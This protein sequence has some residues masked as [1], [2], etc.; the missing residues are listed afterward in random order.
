LTYCNI[1]GAEWFQV[2]YR[3]SF[4]EER[5]VFLYFSQ[6]RTIGT[7][8]LGPSGLLQQHSLTFCGGSTEWSQVFFQPRPE[9]TGRPTGLLP[10]TP[11]NRPLAGPLPNSCFGSHRWPP[12]LMPRPAAALAWRS[13]ARCVPLP[14]CPSAPLPQLLPVPGHL[15]TREKATQSLIKYTQYIIYTH[16]SVLWPKGNQN[17][18][19][20][21]PLHSIASVLICITIQIN[22]M[23]IYVCHIY[24]C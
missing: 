21:L 9:C 23:S 10:P 17:A 15:V 19:Y 8:Q 4:E 12:T 24:Y 5:W 11:Q 22:L 1:T 3:I 16:K 7:S 20:V 6:S 13:L 18:Y 2:G 14:L